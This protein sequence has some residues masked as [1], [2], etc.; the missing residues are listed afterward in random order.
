MLIKVERSEFRVLKF[1]VRERMM[2]T[3][4]YNVCHFL[5]VA[6]LVS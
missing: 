1:L 6:L 2:L 3:F 4:V 5:Y